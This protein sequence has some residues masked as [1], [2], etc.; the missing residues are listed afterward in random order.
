MFD[1]TLPGG[2][3]ARGYVADAGFQELTVH[4]AVNPIGEWVRAGHA[5]F[6]AGDAVAM[7]WL[8]RECGA[9]LQ[10]SESRFHCRRRLLPQ[11]EALPV[12]P[13]GFV[14]RGSVIM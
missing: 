9:W 8:E 12:E 3:P 14:D 2:L 7:G 4:A 11:L 10:S 13:H 1:F 5:G 6:D